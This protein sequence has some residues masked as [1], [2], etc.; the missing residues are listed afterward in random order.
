MAASDE[1][2][3]RVG[4]VVRPG[5]EVELYATAPWTFRVLI[6][7]RED[8]RWAATLARQ[9]ADFPTPPWGGDPGAQVLQHFA[10]SISGE[11]EL[12]DPPP[13]EPGTIY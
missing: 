13:G 7:G 5:I 11:V 4:R 1:M 3:R 9:Y 6:Q 10:R 8:A 12:D 2:P